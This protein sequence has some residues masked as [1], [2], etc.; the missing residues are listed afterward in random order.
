[1]STIKVLEELKLVNS[2]CEQLATEMQTIQDAYSRGDLSREERD[3][4][5]NEICEVRAARET[6][7]NEIAMRKVVAAARV[8]LAL[9]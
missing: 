6:A 7:G 2:A 3:Y 4:L 5:L 9:I 1:M 8:L